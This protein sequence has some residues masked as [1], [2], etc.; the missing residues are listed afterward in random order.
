MEFKITDGRAWYKQVVSGLVLGHMLVAIL[1]MLV[2]VYVGL[3]LVS[4][5]LLPI[6]K[7]T[8]F[9]WI[10]IAFIGAIGAIIQGIWEW[11]TDED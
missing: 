1:M 5:I 4:S 11:A 9:I 8:V 2:C 6:L 10:I 7:Y 3:Q